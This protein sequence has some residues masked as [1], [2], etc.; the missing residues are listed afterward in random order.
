M[1]GFWKDQFHDREVSPVNPVKPIMFT[2]WKD[3]SQY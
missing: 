3:G 2:L 1:F